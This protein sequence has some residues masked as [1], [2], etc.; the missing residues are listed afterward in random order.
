MQSELLFF[1]AKCNRVSIQKKGFSDPA[2]GVPTIS[3]GAD[4]QLITRLALKLES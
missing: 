3:P 2:A 4:E 1:F